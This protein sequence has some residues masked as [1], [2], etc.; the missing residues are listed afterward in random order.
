MG[1]VETVALLAQVDG[2]ER[3]ELPVSVYHKNGS[4]LLAKT[5]IQD[6]MTV[7]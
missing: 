1:K 2:V 6:T 5:G 7:S 4:G 3:E